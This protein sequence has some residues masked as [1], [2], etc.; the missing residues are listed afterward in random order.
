MQTALFFQNLSFVILVL[1]FFFDGAV[2]RIKTGNWSLNPS[3]KRSRGVLELIWPGL[4]PRDFVS[5]IRSLYNPHLIDKTR[6][7]GLISGWYHFLREQ[8]STTFGVR[9]VEKGE[10]TSLSTNERVSESKLLPLCF[11]A[12]FA[13]NSGQGSHLFR[14]FVK[15]QFFSRPSV[16][17]NVRIT[18]STFIFQ[19]SHYF[20]RWHMFVTNW[21]TFGQ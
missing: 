13:Q 14:N 16:Y 1:Y 4:G 5:S 17:I 21:H 20:Y 15:F 8:K 9:H 3:S 2:V 19:N 7:F 18:F 10:N 6:V 11:R 12:S